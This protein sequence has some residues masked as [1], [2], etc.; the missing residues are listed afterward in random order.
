MCDLSDDAQVIGAKEKGKQDESDPRERE[1][2][3]TDPMPMPCHGFV[4]HVYGRL[5]RA[6]SCWVGNG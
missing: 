4:L 6:L 1:K 5:F 2:N 3:L